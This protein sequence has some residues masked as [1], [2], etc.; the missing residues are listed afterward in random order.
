MIIIIIND[1]YD[2][3]KDNQFNSRVYS[4]SPNIH[5]GRSSIEVLLAIKDDNTGDRTNNMTHDDDDAN[6]IKKEMVNK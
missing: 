4:S 1:K 2:T 6:D 5:S 3:I